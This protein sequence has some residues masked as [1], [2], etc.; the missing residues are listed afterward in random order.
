MVSAIEKSF[1]FSMVIILKECSDL[2]VPAAQEALRVSMIF[3]YNSDLT[4]SIVG[5]KVNSI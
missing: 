4:I 5:F 2:E 1:E 3:I